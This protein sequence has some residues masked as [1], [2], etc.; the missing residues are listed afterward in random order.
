M[1]REGGLLEPV[2]GAV[3][4]GHAKLYRV[5]GRAGIGEGCAQ[6]RRQPA[7]RERLARMKRAGLDAPTFLLAPD[8]TDRTQVS[9]S[10]KY[11]LSR[12]FYFA[13]NCDKCKRRLNMKH[14]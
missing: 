9:Q 4:V 7:G 5:E 6:R 8:H 3:D 12:R 10:I 11:R 2:L 1:Q 14:P 13:C